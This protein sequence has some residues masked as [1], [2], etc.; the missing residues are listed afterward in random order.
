M[1]SDNIDIMVPLEHAC[2]AD[3]FPGAPLLPGA[4]LLQWIFARLEQAK[5]IHIGYIHQVKFLQP[6]LPGN[7]LRI[8]FLMQ[9]NKQLRF[10]CYR[11]QTL[12]AKG[13][14]GYNLESNDE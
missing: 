3:H 7:Q 12:I 4:L 2:F 13:K 5:N 10:D 9:E 14:L 1:T 11:D 8:T 6:V